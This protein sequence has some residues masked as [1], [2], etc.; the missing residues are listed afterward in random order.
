MENI[1]EN[2]IDQDA[3]DA[4]TDEQVAEVLSILNKAGY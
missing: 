1:W 2:V 3:V 4:L